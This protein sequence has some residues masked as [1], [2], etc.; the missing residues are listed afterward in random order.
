MFSDGIRQ[1]LKRDGIQGLPRL[2][3]I[4]NDRINRDLPQAWLYLQLSGDEGF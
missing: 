4:G 1:F 3:G 2:M